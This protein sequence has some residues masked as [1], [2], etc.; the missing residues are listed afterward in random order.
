MANLNLRS[1]NFNLFS[2]F[3]Y[4]YRKNPGNSF[5]NSRYL[6][7]DTNETSSFT[8]ESRENETE[9]QKA[10]RLKGDGMEIYWRTHKHLKSETVQ[11][12]LRDCENDFRVVLLSTQDLTRLYFD[13]YKPKSNENENV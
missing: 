3:G 7:A 8:N 12:E 6:D 1:T 4:N 10:E 11:Q 2:N 13:D 9:S 5:T